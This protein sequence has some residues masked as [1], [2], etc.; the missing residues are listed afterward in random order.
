MSLD[1]V[2]RRRSASRPPSTRP[3]PIRAF[4]GPRHPSRPRSRG[5]RDR[6]T[7]LDHRD[8]QARGSVGALSEV[9]A[10]QDRTTTSSRPAGPL[11]RVAMVATN[12]SGTTDGSSA[13]I[14]MIGSRG[15][16]PPVDLGYRLLRGPEAREPVPARGGSELLNTTELGRGEHAPSES[17][18]VE[19]WID[20]LD[21]DA[22][23]A[24]IDD[25]DEQPVG[26]C[27]DA[28]V[29]ARPAKVGCVPVW[30]ARIPARRRDRAPGRDLARPHAPG[31]ARRHPGFCPQRAPL[32]EVRAQQLG[33]VHG[34]GI[35]GLGSTVIPPRLAPHHTAHARHGQAASRSCS[36]RPPASARIVG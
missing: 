6:R 14:S 11:A 25:R 34:G 16:T 26:T 19:D 32:L 18:V 30:S 29:H 15:Q 9:G 1:T 17:G 21:V 22:D 5:G 20:A 4:A 10:G 3:W 13:A 12:S 31:G 36:A 2:G 24:A 35:H 23:R 28:E 7:R 27:G 33:D 8:S